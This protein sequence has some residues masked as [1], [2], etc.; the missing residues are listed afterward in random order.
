MTNKYDVAICGGGLVGLT[1]GLAL[2]R[3]GVETAIIDSTPLDDLLS[4]DFDGRA[5]SIA[6]GSKNVLSAIGVWS[7]LESDAQPILQIRVSDGNSPL[8]LHYDRLDLGEEPLGWMVENRILRI[9]LLKALKNFNKVSHFAPES[10]KSFNVSDDIAIMKLSNGRIIESSLAVAADGRNSFLRSESGIKNIELSYNQVGIVCT[11]KHQF[12]HQGIAHEKFLPSGPFAILPL[13]SNRSSLVW[14]ENSVLAPKILSLDKE[15]FLRELLHRF[16]DFLGEIELEGPR[17]SY[18][19]SLSYAK[20]YVAQRTALIGDSAHSIHPIAGQGFNLG[21]RDCAA[22]AEVIVETRRL[23]LDV[24]SEDLLKQYQRFRRFDS[25]M[26]TAV[27]HGL[28]LLFS[29]QN[30]SLQI[31]RRFGLA[32]INQSPPIKKF[33]MRHAMGLIGDLP[34]LVRGEQI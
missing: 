7:Y 19:L 22:L 16:G 6:L 15:D 31:I 20:E 27:T 11:V 10:V 34:R 1:L 26:F 32:G 33:F 17:W 12:P 24:G 8:F 28:N 4:K 18:P 30:S 3:Y 13:T 5:S 23:G 21:I 2:A 25:A 14:T 9:S 29:N